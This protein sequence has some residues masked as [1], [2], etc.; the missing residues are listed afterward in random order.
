MP[1]FCKGN[2]DCWTLVAPRKSYSSLTFLR[3]CPMPRDWCMVWGSVLNVLACFPGCP[4]ASLSTCICTYNSIL[5]IFLQPVSR[6]LSSYCVIFLFFLPKVF[7]FL[8][9]NYP[10]K[11][12]SLCS[13]IHTLMHMS[14]FLSYEKVKCEAEERYDDHKWQKFVTNLETWSWER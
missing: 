13:I 14:F 2:P 1:P 5:Q 10:G 4:E 7:L 8:K 11:G 12:N 6:N 9:Y 3:Q